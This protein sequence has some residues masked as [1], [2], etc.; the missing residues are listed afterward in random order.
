MQGNELIK[1]PEYGCGHVFSQEELAGATQMVDHNLHTGR[2][3]GA[4]ELQCPLCRSFIW[5]LS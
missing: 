3:Q 4:L 5:V 2:E 1:C